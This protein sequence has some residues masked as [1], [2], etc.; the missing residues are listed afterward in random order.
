MAGSMA[1]K[2][3]FAAKSTSLVNL[4]TNAKY[5]KY[6][7]LFSSLIICISKT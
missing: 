7:L 5:M 3:F 4:H 1:Y 2:D 6:I